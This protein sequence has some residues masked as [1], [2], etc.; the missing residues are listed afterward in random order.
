[1]PITGIY[2]AADEHD[3]RK[4]STLHYVRAIIYIGS[5]A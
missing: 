1:M 4:A 2:G 5:R 3:G